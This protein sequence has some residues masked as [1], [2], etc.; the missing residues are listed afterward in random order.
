MKKVFV[1]SLMCMIA[2]SINAQEKKDSYF[3]WNQSVRW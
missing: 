1:L 2:L 3:G